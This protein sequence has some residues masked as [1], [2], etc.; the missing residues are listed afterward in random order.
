VNKKRNRPRVIREPNISSDQNIISGEI[1]SGGISIQGGD[2]HNI[3]ITQNFNAPSPTKDSP[4]TNETIETKPFEPKPIL[5]PAGSFIMG[6][7]K[8]DIKLLIE[9]FGGNEDKYKNETPEQEVSLPSYRIG[10]YP[11]TNQQYKEFIRQN[12]KTRI[13]SII[14]SGQ[15]APSEG[16]EDLPVAG[17][18]WYEAHAYCEWLGQITSRKYS[19]PNEAQ[20][21]KAFRGGKNYFYPWGDEFDATR[22]NQGQPGVAPVTKYPAQ[23]EF[24]CFDLVGNVMQWTCTLW[25][26]AR[27][28]PR[29]KYSYPWQ[30][31]GRNDSNDNPGILRVIRGSSMNQDLIGHRCSVRRGEDP[32]LTGVPG[33]RYGFRV[34]INLS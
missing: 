31:D 1:S 27:G 18:T 26:I 8:E 24:G 23:N 15:M 11:V 16:F 14:W 13:S 33:A 29:P 12:P 17:A 25:G 2:R 32:G 9:K 19:L 21:E 4:L 28:S 5:I 34:V 6:T 7:K 10:K 20:W 3:N 22:C 30:D